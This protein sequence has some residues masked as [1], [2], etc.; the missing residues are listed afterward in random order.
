[1]VDVG[2]SCQARSSRR[3]GLPVGLSIAEK[4][5]VQEARGA[6]IVSLSTRHGVETGEACSER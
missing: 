4:V 3:I 1:M 5:E 2:P 6:A